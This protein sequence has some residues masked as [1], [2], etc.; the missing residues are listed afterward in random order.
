MPQNIHKRL[1][2]KNL[3][4]NSQE[5]SEDDL[6]K[7]YWQKSYVPSHGII[8]AAIFSMEWQFGKEKHTCLYYLIAVQLGANFVF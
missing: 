7:F 5:E 2:E 8:L 6:K 4:N 1:K 3:H